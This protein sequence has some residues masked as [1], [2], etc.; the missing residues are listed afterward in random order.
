MLAELAAAYIQHSP[1]AWKKGGIFAHIVTPLAERSPAMKTVT[2]PAG[3]FRCNTRDLVQRYIWV[4]HEWEP[5]QSAYVRATLK[6]GDLF[7]DVGANVGYYSVLA[8][9]LGARVVAI[10]PSPSIF[11]RLKEHVEMNAV[12]GRL[13]QIAVSDTEGELPIYRSD[14]TN[15][16]CTTLVQERGY[17]FEGVVPVLPIATAL[18]SD[19]IRTMRLMKLDVEGVA[20]EAVR[21]LMPALAHTRPDFEVLSELDIDDDPAW[22]G[23]VAEM[24][25][26]AGFNA[27][28]LDNRYGPGEYARRA[29]RHFAPRCNPASGEF[30]DVLFSR[31]DVEAISWLPPAR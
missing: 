1:I 5:A 21:G 2:T 30:S 13:L 19:E 18:T 24:F 20:V 10:E 22:P 6:P 14:D 8:G 28:A 16:G 26:A 11:A 31:R 29:H 4:W 12:N 23:Q 3:T 7:I 15:T 9:S 25:A 17:A 27:Y